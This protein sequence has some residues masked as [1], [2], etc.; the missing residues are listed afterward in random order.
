MEGESLVIV[1]KQN[2][3]DKPGLDEAFGGRKERGKQSSIIRTAV[4]LLKPVRQLP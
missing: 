1:G 2:S 3:G 4:N